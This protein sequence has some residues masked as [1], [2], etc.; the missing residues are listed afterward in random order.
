MA[1]SPLSSPSWT[2]LA[3]QR[4]HHV[5]VAHAGHQQRL[6]QQLQGGAPTSG[7]RGGGGGSGV[8]G[9]EEDRVLLLHLN[10]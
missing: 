5:Q 4:V 8:R 7:L 9:L 6:A 10:V 2:H 3:L 1:A